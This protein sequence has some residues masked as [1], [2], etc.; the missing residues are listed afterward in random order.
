MDAMLLVQKAW[1]ESFERVKQNKRAIAVRG[2]LPLNY[3][4]LDHPD[5]KKQADKNGVFQAYEQLSLTGDV[6]MDPNG[7]N[8]EDGICGKLLE[9]LIDD[10]NWQHGCEDIDQNACLVTACKKFDSITTG[11]TDGALFAGG[12]TNV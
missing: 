12:R 2:W 11:V 10:K 8:T 3:V 7:L 6:P 9:K 4:L 5:L 1:S